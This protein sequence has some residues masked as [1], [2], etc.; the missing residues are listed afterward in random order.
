MILRQNRRSNCSDRGAATQ[1]ILMSVYRTPKLLGLHPAKTIANA[2]K[3]YLFTS[4][5]PPRS[6]ADTAN[7]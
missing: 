5:L 7:G 4:Q 3:T 6:D 1:A 2:L